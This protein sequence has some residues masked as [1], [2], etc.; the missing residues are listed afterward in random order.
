MQ[1]LSARAL[2]RLRRFRW[3]FP[4]LQKS[5]RGTGPRN[6]N[7]HAEEHPAIPTRWVGLHA[8][9]YFLWGR[10]NIIFFLRDF[11]TQ[12]AGVPGAGLPNDRAGVTLG[13]D[14]K[15]FGEQEI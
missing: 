8:E 14:R 2:L 11:P 13:G 5:A 15:L 10:W 4:C 9:Y 7:A 12:L 1:I 6:G 3:G